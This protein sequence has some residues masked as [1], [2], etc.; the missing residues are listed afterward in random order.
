[1]RRLPD[2]GAA[3]STA[4]CL[5][6][7]VFIH[8]GPRVF[9]YYAPK[10]VGETFRDYLDLHQGNPALDVQMVLTFRDVW[11]RRVVKRRR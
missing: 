2:R 10:K 9:T 1:M 7:Y 6:T 4:R 11:P 5:A 8:G 3:G